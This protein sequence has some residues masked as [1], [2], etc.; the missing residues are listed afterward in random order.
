MLMAMIVTA[1]M[2]VV[3]VALMGMVPRMIIVIVC[4]LFAILVGVAVV[5]VGSPV[6]R[7]A[8]SDQSKDTEGCEKREA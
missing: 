4:M 6:L 8:N 1:L 5:V 7:A 2:R 3:I